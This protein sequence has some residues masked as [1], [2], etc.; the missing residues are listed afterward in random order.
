[1]DSS[2]KDAE[3]FCLCLMT[4][5]VYLQIK[6]KEHLIEYQTFLRGEIN[7]P[8]YKTLI[9]KINDQ[10]LCLPTIF[11]KIRIHAKGIDITKY[12]MRLVITLLTELCSKSYTDIEKIERMK[13]LNADKKLNKSFIKPNISI[14]EMIDNYN[15]IKM[16]S[17]SSVTPS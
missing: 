12:S 8:A 10:I 2:E 14:D 3:E 16:K 7:F 17:Y 5:I 11:D 15:L 6:F 1:M 13:E 9:K 4:L